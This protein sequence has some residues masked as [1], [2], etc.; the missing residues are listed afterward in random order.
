MSISFLHCHTT[1]TLGQ[2]NKQKK[3]IF[4]L[5]LLWN[6]IKIIQG[7]LLKY[8]SQKDNGITLSDGYRQ[9]QSLLVLY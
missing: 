1:I 9:H 2:I 5:N 6:L 3:I 8:S 7:T 4:L